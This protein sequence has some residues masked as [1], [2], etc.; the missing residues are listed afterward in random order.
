MEN[1]CKALSR[2]PS[3][4]G[5][6]S[7]NISPQKYYQWLLMSSQTVLTGVIRNY[8]LFYPILLSAQFNT[9]IFLSLPVFSWAPRSVSIA[10]DYIW[11]HLSTCTWGSMFSR[12]GFRGGTSPVP[13]YLYI[14]VFI[15]SH[16]LSFFFLCKGKM[17]FPITT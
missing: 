15:P 9:K 14:Y 8:F 5:R 6:H 2:M 10:A 13:F 7:V 16:L 12:D 1:V 4:Y 3:P 17:S 11:G